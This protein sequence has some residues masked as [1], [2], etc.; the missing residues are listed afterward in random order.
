MPTAL[1]VCVGVGAWAA[2]PLLIAG[3]AL[4][5]A[6][7]RTETRANVGGGAA[8]LFVTAITW[9][10]LGHTTRATEFTHL[11][12]GGYVGALL[13]A[14]L[15]AGFADP[16]NHII[17]GAI[18][19]GCIVWATDRRLLHLLGDAVQGGR[20]VAAPVVKGT[21]AVRER[22]KREGKEA[23]PAP[24]VWGEET[25]EGVP[26][27]QSAQGQ[28]RSKNRELE[29]PPPKLGGPGGPDTDDPPTVPRPP[30]W[31]PPARQ[32]PPAP[33]AL[34]NVAPD[35]PLLP[36]PQHSGED[37]APRPFVLPPLS[38]LNEA[39]P[40]PV[41]AGGDG[42][43]KQ[44]ILMQTLQD[45]RIGANVAEVAHGPTVTR[46]EVQLEPGIL[47]KKIVALA[48]NLAMSLA[49]IDVRVE[50]P[51]PGKAA[52]G[53]EVPNDV[54]EMVLPARVPVHRRVCPCAV[55]TD[56]SRSARTFPA[57]T[58]TPTSRECPICW[59]AAAR[60]SGKSVCLN[61]IICSILYRATPREVRFVMIDP[62]R[63]ELS[64]Y[65]GIPHL[66]S[67]VVKNV[68]QAAGIFRAVLKEMED[69]YDK[70]RP[71]GNAQH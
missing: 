31:T 17:L 30:V 46:Y 40:R 23:P 6:G 52:I 71:I 15:R 16:V 60:N 5:I 22:V 37:D 20:K 34:A 9:W 33:A 10:H 53:I 69:R 27:S 50:A 13:T 11:A 1:R 14:A 36:T 61:A 54:T 35:A 7:R 59:W 51:I 4:L 49:A 28:K 66:L 45:F 47:V 65:D 29:L 18:A 41:R 48:D 2:P 43:D 56:P 68:K 55:Q 32:T 38:L 21:Q 19:A 39:P 62:K 63:V 42:A 58:N 12:P 25:T 64:L 8:A 67:P 70:F 3:G 24:Q 26:A 44:A 57:R